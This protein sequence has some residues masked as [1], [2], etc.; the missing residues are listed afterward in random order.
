MKN[1]LRSSIILLFTF[2]FVTGFLYPILITGIAQVVFPWQANGSILKTVDGKPIGSQIIGQSFQYPGHFWSRPSAT[3][4]FPYN[5]GASG[6]SNLSVLNETIS[7]NVNE[8]ISHIS[9]SDMVKNQPIPIDLITAS[10]SGLDPHIS[11]QAALFQVPRIAHIRGLPEKQVSDLVMNHV[12]QP[13]AFLIGEPR[14][15][16]LLLNLALDSVQYT[17]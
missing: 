8:R 4:D 10:A 16:V 7:A 3:S 11:P 9:Q 2:A 14:V 5:A 6:G 15:N 13:I 17:K 1:I 12:E